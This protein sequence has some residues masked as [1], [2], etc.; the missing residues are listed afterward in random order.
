L[1]SIS[2]DEEVKTVRDRKT[3]KAGAG[4][5]ESHPYRVRLPG[6][7]TDEEVGLGDI[8]KHATHTFGINACGGCERRAAM[9]NRWF[10]FTGG[11]KSRNLS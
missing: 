11:A 3:R 6:F 2:N 4:Q 1:G 8:I 5:S 7:I 9:L 10:V